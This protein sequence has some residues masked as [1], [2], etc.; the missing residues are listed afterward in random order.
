[1]DVCRLH[2]SK[3]VW[4]DFGKDSAHPRFPVRDRSLRAGSR[5]LFESYHSLLKGVPLL[6]DEVLDHLVQG[7]GMDGFMIQHLLPHACVFRGFTGKECKPAVQSQTDA[8]EVWR[9]ADRAILAR[10][11]AMGNIGIDEDI[12]RAEHHCML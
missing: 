9:I 6:C 5:G 8:H 3:E 2:G 11:D 12:V 1:M 10:H 7:A 4:S